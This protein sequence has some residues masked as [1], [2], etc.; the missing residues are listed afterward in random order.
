[1][2]HS[3]QTIVAASSGNTA[4]ALAM[5]SAMRGYQCKLIT[6]RKTSQEKIQQLGAYGAEVIITASGVPVDSPEHYQN[7]ETRLVAENPSW[8]G[9]NQCKQAKKPGRSLIVAPRTA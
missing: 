5:F 7:V 4:A 3:G 1:M 6:N 8:I 2:R 9:L